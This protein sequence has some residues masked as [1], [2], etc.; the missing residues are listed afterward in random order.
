VRGDADPEAIGPTVLASVYAKLGW[1]MSAVVW[2]SKRCI[3]PTVAAWAQVTPWIEPGTQFVGAS[4]GPGE[5]RPRRSCSGAAHGGPLTAFLAA[6][7]RLVRN[8]PRRRRQARNAAPATIAKPTRP[9]SKSTIGPGVPTGVAIAGPQSKA[10]ANKA[11]QRA[12]FI[13]PTGS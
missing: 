12:I 5:G 6:A 11:S 3:G 7:R 13:S 9:A 1:R 2:W 8:Q 10:A 4:R